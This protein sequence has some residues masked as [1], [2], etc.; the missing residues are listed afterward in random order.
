VIPCAPSVR[1]LVVALVVASPSAPSTAAEVPAGVIPPG[2]DAVSAATPALPPSIGRMMQEG[3]FAEAAGALE[4]PAREAS[5]PA[6][7][8]YL[9]LIRATALRLA[10]KLDEARVV[11]VAAIEAS[12]KGPWAPKLRGD[13]AAVHLA[14]GRPKEAEALARADVSALLAGDRKD[15]LAGVY[16]AYA[17]RLLA[18]D[19]PFAKPDPEAAH[20]LLVQARSAARGEPLRARLLFEAASASRK[21]GQIGRAVEEYQAYVK[22]APAGPDR[23]AAR[24]AM[25]EALEAAGRVPAARSTWSDLARENRPG[26]PP[27][28]ADLR[29]RALYRIAWTYAAPPPPDPGR[30]GFQ[31]FGPVAAPSEGRESGPIRAASDED[32]GLQVAALRRLIAADPA[33]PLAVKAAFEVGAIFQ[34]RGKGQEALRAY[35]AFLA[36]EGFQAEGEESRRILAGRT[37]DA[38]FAVGEVLKSQGR[39]DDAIAAWAEYL[40]RYPAG[41]GSAGA[42]RA[43][44]DARL[45]SA[46]DLMRR[47]IYPEARAAWRS[48]IDQNPLDARVPGLLVRVAEGFRAEGKADEAVAA[49]ESAIA[50]SGAAEPVDHARFLL[51]VL[52]EED[53]G[54]PERAIEEYR[55][56]RPGPWFGRARQRVAVMETP[57]LRVVTPRAFRSGEPARLRIGSRNLGR[58]SFAAYRLD[59]EAFFR[60]KQALKGVEALD[61]GLVA[62]D[63]EWSEPV[64]GYARYRSVEADYD[65]K[66]LEGA[67]FWAVK[68]TDEATLQA[69]TMVLRSD[70]EAVVKAS[71]RQ[72]LVFVQDMRTGQGRKGARVILSDGKE[73]VMEARAGD[74]GVV[75]GDWPTPREPK[76]VLSTL[77]LDGPDAAGSGLSLPDRVA[78]GLTRRVYLYTDRPAYRPGQPVNLR[79]V[80]RE[81]ADGSYSLTPGAEY[82]LEVADARGRK[83]LARSVALSGFGT[84]HA[85]MTLAEGSTVG[86]YTIKLSWP[87]QGESSGRFEVQSYELEKADLRVDLPS[88]VVFRGETIRADV[89]A[90]YQYGTPLAGRAV[91]VGLPDGRTI[92]GKTDPAGRFHVEFPTE[93]FAEEQSLRIT[94][95]LPEENVS[96]S[97]DL[98][99]AVRAFRIDLESDRTVYLDGESF[100]LRA[101]TVDAAGGPIGESLTVSVLKRVHREGSPTAEREVASARLATDPKAGRGEVTLK[102]DDGDGG[103]YILRAMGTDRFGNPVFED[104]AIAISGRKDAARLR[105]LAD[106]QSFQVGEPARVNLHNRA[107]AG[108]ALLAWEA[109]RI[110][111]YRLVRVAPGDNALEWEVDG[112]QFPNFTLAAARMDGT[113]LDEARLDVKVTRD[114]RVE[115]KPVRPTVGPGEEVVVE[116]ST[117]DQLDRP[118]AAELSLALVDRALLRLHADAVPPIG[119]F[120]HDRDRTGAFATVATNGFRYAPEARSVAAPA[121]VA[122]RT[123][124]PP[125]VPGSN[126]F[127]PGFAPGP[128]GAEGGMVA[129]PPKAKPYLKADDLRGGIDD[130]VSRAIIAKLGGATAMNFPNETPLE[131]VVKYVSQATQDEA[132]GLPTGIPIYV[133]PVG[134]QDADKTMA[135]TVTFN[136]EG[137]PLKTALR[138]LLAQIG[139]TYHVGEGLLTI[140]STSADDEPELGVQPGGGFGG[141]G[142]MGGGGMGGMGG[143]RMG[144]MGGGF[145]GMGRVRNGV[146]EPGAP[147]PAAGDEAPP[148]PRAAPVAAEQPRAPEPQPAPVPARQQ[149]VETAF[150]APAVVTGQDGKA[151]VTFRAPTALSEYVFMARGITGADTLAGQSTADLA[152]RKGLFVDFRRPPVLIQGDRPRFSAR[153]HHSGIRGKIEVKLAA[154]AGD[155]QQVDPRALDVSADGD[156][157]VRFDAFDVPDGDVVRL[158]CTARAGDQS[159]EVVAEIPIRPWGVQEFATASG[160]SSDDVAAFVALPAGRSF[161]S[162]EML[163]TIAPTTGRLLLETALGADSLTAEARR[164]ACV[165]PGRADTT[166][167]RASDLLAAVS[168]LRYLRAVAAGEDDGAARLADR[169]R[170][171]VAGL[172]ATQNEDGGWPWVAGGRPAP[173]S[174]PEVSARV[175]WALS[176]AEPLGML[177][178]PDAVNKAAAY[179]TQQLAR[180]DATDHDNRAALLHALATRG[181]A[182]FEATNALHRIRDDLSDTAL[183]YLALLL[184]RVDRPGPADEVLDLLGRRAESEPGA[185]GGKARRRWSAGL[186]GPRGRTD[187]EPT[188]MAALAFARIRTRPVDM[189]GA[190]EW[191]LAHRSG[192]DWNPHKSSGIALAALSAYYSR[193]RPESDRYRLTVSVNGREVS[194]GEVAGP[195]EG[196]TIAV[197]RAALKPSG[198]NQVSFDIEGRGTFGYSVVLTGFT[199]DFSPPAGPARQPFAVRRSYLASAP[200]FEGRPLPIGFKVAVNPSKFENPA[201]QLALGGRVRVEIEAAGRTTEDRSGRARPYLIL[202]EHLPAGTS[203]VEGSVVSNAAYHR[204]ADGVLTFYFDPD[205][206]ASGVRY[207]LYG[208]L[209]GNFR[210]L[211]A[212]LRDADD[213]GVSSPGEPG[214]I[215]VMA[216]G[217]PITDPYRPTPDERYARGKALFDS[218]RV[219]DAAAALE[220]LVAGSTLRDDVRKDVARMLLYSHLVSN[221]P[222]K[223]VE[224]FETIREKAPD[225]VIPFETLLA[226]GRAYADIDEHERAYLGWRALAEAS[227]LEDSRVGEAIR[228][229]GRPLEA[230]AFLI[231]LWRDYPDEAS[232]QSDFFDLSRLLAGLAARADSDPAVR[233]DLA[234]AKVTGDDVLRQAARLVDVFLARSPRNPLAD[235]A[236]LALIGDELELKDFAEVVSLAE[237]SGA[238]Y[239]GSKLLDRFRYSEA[240]GR[241]HLGQHDRAVEIAAALAAR[242]ETPGDDAASDRWRAVFLLGQIEEAR[243][244]PAEAL[245]HYRQVAGRS[246]DAA[247]AVEALTRRVLTLPEI[248][249]VR[250]GAAPGLPAKGGPEVAMTYRNIAEVEVKVYPVDL[251]RFALSR[252]GLVA[253]SSIDLSGVRPLIQKDWKLGDGS[254][255]QDKVRPLDLPMKDEGA[256]LVIVRGGNLFASGIVLVTDLELDVTEQ[257]A[258]GLLRVTARDASTGA[259]VPEVQV[260]VIGS[261]NGEFVDGRTDLRGVFLAQGLRGTAAVVARQGTSRYAL[262]RGT[263]GLGPVGKPGVVPEG[264]RSATLEDGLGE[265]N[266]ANPGRQLERFDKRSGGMG[267]M[268]G[269]MRGGGFM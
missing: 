173:P 142:G 9:G 214:E 96:A 238:L 203:L 59:P 197:P 241:F 65:L 166:A 211:P 191:L 104:R 91:D 7:R 26:G 106:R 18:T 119:P 213:P 116:V 16:R 228:Q 132:A 2:S 206:L 247:E 98:V 198:R 124:G 222:R 190:V 83:V 100:R 164:S 38:M 29:A 94:A 135:S 155:R 121:R 127:G 146:V 39:P 258:G 69:T 101:R 205:R 218:G 237:R 11:L 13:L 66:K 192:V 23:D 103:D 37:M 201:G 147:I 79:G 220:A 87:G 114:L 264:G 158:V 223:I 95:R 89:V 111:R 230:A 54:E 107:G 261:G 243:G 178:D 151:R 93:G 30:G 4:R 42:Q 209:A 217:E 236:S 177:P 112:A 34:A 156:D 174:D 144:G 14:Q 84:F 12:P 248:A 74:D 131:D 128:P 182:G 36:G 234:A 24:F 229:R 10:G 129:H 219:V 157:E 221:Q 200:E 152:V 225:L 235:E 250:P 50:R 126:P 3:K 188:A 207:E 242:E 195:A 130:P 263:T 53:R 115:I 145:G 212:R 49:F 58:L 167:D 48:F 27:A 97:A 5:D 249:V 208:N 56:V 139:L 267:G 133:D 253:A 67:G 102:V 57:T 110:L 179:L 99:L 125:T 88:P 169:A 159:D 150:W 138:L 226:V 184:A 202:E 19:G 262:F 165:P 199:R 72:F 70:L 232:I 252:R 266:R 244:R 251:M 176:E 171:L 245:A 187:V 224:D 20:G 259:R 85:S 215:R 47:R 163:V 21:A 60:K 162:P 204:L 265:P 196:R 78:Q 32:L 148:E 17:A 109:D 134:L 194:K 86:T 71:G 35:R 51:G 153:V 143:G 108:L 137:V 81:V 105:I 180:S 73:T 61:V 186:S 90:R 255:F 122:A 33:H 8:A 216:P 160:V 240:L 239:P 52:F 141:M 113:R 170:G 181:R 231:G 161:E 22:E 25:G 175:V 75:L 44:L 46:D 28:S 15:R 31:S 120:F 193:A 92:R 172:V 233:D 269:G 45:Q 117:L 149:F 68:V 268:G 6:A 210:A 123:G 257:A 76:G 246:T 185:P 256:F 63:A 254:D 183:A 227:Y 43:I 55:K 40:A 140:T 189:E 41:S 168:A 136:M 260:K 62:P 1:L 77:V 64:P 154:Y 80:V 82:K 118:V